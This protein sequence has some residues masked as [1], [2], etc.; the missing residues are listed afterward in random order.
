MPLI[1]FAIST[2]VSSE[3]NAAIVSLTA[4]FGFTIGAGLIPQILGLFGNAKL[5]PQGFILFGLVCVLSALIFSSQGAYN[6]KLVL[7]R[8]K[9]QK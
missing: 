9:P 5:Y 3:K 1:H 8:L 2:L 4:P 7:E 6:E